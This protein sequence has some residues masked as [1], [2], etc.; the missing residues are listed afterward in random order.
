MEACFEDADKEF[1]IMD[2]LEDKSKWL[3]GRY[4]LFNTHKELNEQYGVRGSPTLV[5]NGATSG[6]GRD[7]ASYLAGICEAF[8]EAP[9]AC[10][11]ELS[12]ESYGAGFGYDVAA[13]ASGGSC[14]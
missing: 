11:T 13:A 12:T 3:N 10:N 1:E 7:P 4:P 8:N 9:E 5:I 6:A 2:N 14:S